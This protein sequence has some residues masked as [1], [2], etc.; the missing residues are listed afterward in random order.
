MTAVIY[1]RYSSDSQREESFEGQIRECTA[2]AE[3]NSITIV[4]H[5]IYRAIS[6]SRRSLLLWRG[7]LC[8][9]FYKKFTPAGLPPHTGC[10]MM[11]CKILSGAM[12]FDLSSSRNQEELPCRR[13]MCRK[14]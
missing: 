14:F 12:D 11:R 10:A 2:Y 1:A 13:I 7:F 3:K 9:N 5:Y 4:K 6:F 8:P